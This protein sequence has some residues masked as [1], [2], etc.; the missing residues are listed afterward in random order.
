MS[1]LNIIFGITFLLSGCS[2][3]QEFMGAKKEPVNPS[4]A[5]LLYT[6]GIPRVKPGVMI[7][8]QVGTVSHNP[9]SMIVQVDQ[10]GEITLPY[11]LKN[12]IYCNELTL[13]ALKNKLKKEYQLY[14]K[15]PQVTVTF[16]PYDG[17]GVS[18]WGT[19][20]VLGEVGSPGPVNLTS[21]MSMTVTK[22]IKEAGGLKPFA[23]KRNIVVT[24]YD[25]DGNKIRRKVD[26]KEIG[27]SGDVSKDIFLKAGN[28]IWVPET[29]Y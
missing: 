6:D 26:W 16:A 14:I 20:T 25:K 8:I 24:S 29:W 7:S 9:T 2:I 11:L 3:L 1:A 12:S 19:V 13:D 4:D 21:T 18:P 10:N 17:R 23:D 5:Y 15:E 27:E 28:V 22:A